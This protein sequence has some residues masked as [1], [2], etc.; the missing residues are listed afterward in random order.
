MLRL[1]HARTACWIK[2]PEFADGT[3]FD[4]NNRPDV[5]GIS[6]NAGE[7]GKQILNPAAFTFTGYTIGTVGNAPRGYCFGPNNRN[8][9]V[10]LA[11]NWVFQERFH[12]KFSMDFFNLFNHANFY[13]NQLEGTGFSASNLVCGGS[14]TACSPTN[15]VVTGQ[16]GQPERKLRTGVGGSPRSRTSVHAEVLVLTA[17]TTI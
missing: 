13:G 5:T 15:N 10:Q 7:N 16:I 3:G 1:V 6:C 8:V 2:H 4:N 17:K 12:L 11:K 14:A 9:D